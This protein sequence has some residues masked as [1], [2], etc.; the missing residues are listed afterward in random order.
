MKYQV[1]SWLLNTSL[2]ANSQKMTSLLRS[3]TMIVIVIALI[4]NLCTQTE[5][6]FIINSQTQFQE[7]IMLELYIQAK[8]RITQDLKTQMNCSL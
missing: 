6:Y 8:T 1:Q 5:I 3:M 2:A 7:T 4:L